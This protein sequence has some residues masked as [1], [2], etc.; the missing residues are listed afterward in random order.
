MTNLNR[1]VTNWL[2]TLDRSPLK[3][4]VSARWRGIDIGWAPF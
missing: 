3:P 2:S 4:I 1:K